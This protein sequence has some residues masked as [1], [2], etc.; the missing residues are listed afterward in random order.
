MEYKNMHHMMTRAGVKMRNSDVSVTT[1]MQNKKKMKV[2]PSDTRAKLS[3]IL[4]RT[5]GCV[6]DKKT[7]RQMKQMSARRVGLGLK[8]GRPSATRPGLDPYKYSIWPESGISGHPQDD[9]APGIFADIIGDDYFDGSDSDNSN[10]STL[11]EEEDPEVEHISDLDD[12]HANISSPFLGFPSSPIRA[13][14]PIDLGEL[15]DDPSTPGEDGAIRG[16]KEMSPTIDPA[17]ASLAE[18][19]EFYSALLDEVEFFMKGA[20]QTLQAVQAL[21][22]ESQLRVEE[23]IRNRG[24]ELKD[25]LNWAEVTLQEEAI[26]LVR[27][28]RAR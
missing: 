25:Q 24:Q 26:E 18:Q 21:D 16:R 7:K 3:D 17:A 1:L 20:D 27:A 15:L 22:P 2:F 28:T 4:I 19:S 9:P 23:Q 13:S 12:S 5:Y 10:D 8:Q 11:L 6:I 14:T